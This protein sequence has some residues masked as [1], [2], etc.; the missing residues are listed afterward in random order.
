MVFIVKSYVHITN[1]LVKMS[2][3]INVLINNIS[4]GVFVWLFGAVC[5]LYLLLY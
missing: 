3:L 1:V 5:V 4:L 2:M